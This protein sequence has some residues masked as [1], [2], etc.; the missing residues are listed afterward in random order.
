M[1]EDMIN[2]FKAKKDVLETKLI[3]TFN[4]ML[5]GSMEIINDLNTTIIQAYED[6]NHTFWMMRY[7]LRLETH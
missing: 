3:L 7:I 1:N 4:Q 5:N 6:H 2:D